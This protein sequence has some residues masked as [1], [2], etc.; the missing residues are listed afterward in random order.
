MEQQKVGCFLRALRNEKGLTQEQLAEKFNI[1]NRSVS[2]WETGKNMP[3][4]SLLVDIADFYDVDVRE[5]IDGERKSGRMKDEVKEVA[6]KMADYADE[7]QSRL[8]NWVRAISLL[9]VVFMTIILALQTF[10]YEPGM[11]VFIC[12]LFSVLAFIVMVIL[13]LYA[14]GILAKIT[15]NKK[16]VAACKI[17]VIGIAAAVALFVVRVLLVIALVVFAE[18]SP[19]KNVTG[20][21]NYDKSY[22]LTTYGGDLDTGLFIFPDNTEDMINPTFVSSLKTGLFDTDGYII[23]HTRYSREQY[24]AEVNRLSD[25]QCVLT[26]DGEEVIQKAKYDEK[27]YAL[28]AYVTV[29]GF[30]YIYEYALVDDKDFSVTYILLSYPETLNM[31]QYTEYLKLDSSEYNIVNA[32]DKF[33]IYAHSFDGGESWMEYSDEKIK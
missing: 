13:T 32:L 18:S 2:R 30:D 23:L 33:S 8:L 29:D 25:I 28:P 1:S 14:N 16:F 24:L 5:I 11:D 17:I 21:E 26:Y 9:G 20:I 22:Y 6:V 15:K 10:R 3:D 31:S 4:I 27:T 12:Y 7:G 19:V